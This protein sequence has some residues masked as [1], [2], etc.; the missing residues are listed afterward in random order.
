MA[1]TRATNYSPGF[2]T[3]YFGRCCLCEKPIPPAHLV[4]EC[5]AHIFEVDPQPKQRELIDILLATGEHVPTRPGFGG[6]RGAAK[7]RG[8]RDAALVVTSEVA[9]RLPGIVT[10]IVRQNWGDVEKNH[11]QEFEREHLPMMEWYKSKEFTFPQEMGGPRITFAY[12][13]T[14]KDLR[15]FTRGPNV[16]LMLIDQAEA[17]TEP[18]LDEL[19]TPNRWPAAG[20]GGAKT[21]YFF[22]PGGPGSEFLG[23]VFYEKNFSDTHLN[24]NDFIF[25]QGYGWDNWQGWF[26]NENVTLDGAPLDKEKFYSLPGEIPPCPLGAYDNKWLATVPDHYRFKIFVTQTSEGK[27][28]WQKPDSIRLGELFG[29]FDVFAGQA[30]AG[31]WNESKIVLR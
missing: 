14:F 16:F 8:L 9:Q 26:A 13:D 23:N 21:A 1:V 5:G 24:P 22:N 12:G 18:E 20:P 31:C 2:T 19:H 29:R 4:C 25:I 10:Y 3:T 6:S 28:M 27:K 30:F 7:S 15:R 11:V 17:F